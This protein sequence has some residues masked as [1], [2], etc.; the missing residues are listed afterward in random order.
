LRWIPTTVTMTMRQTGIKLPRKNFKIVCFNWLHPWN[1]WMDA[2][3]K[4]FSV[5]STGHGDLWM[6][7]GG[8]W[9]GKQQSGQS[10]RR[11]STVQF[12]TMPLICLKNHMRGQLKT[13]PVDNAITWCGC[14]K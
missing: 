12:Q 13:L 7:I 1:I 4:W 2:Q 14:A 8:A 3:L 11:S 5:L 10:K 9:Q 6:L